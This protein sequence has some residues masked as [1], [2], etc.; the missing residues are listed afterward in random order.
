MIQTE[1]NAS[2]VRDIPQLDPSIPASFSTLCPG[3]YAPPTE[4]LSR[5][6]H[7]ITRSAQGHLAHLYHK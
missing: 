3:L 2:A 7:E 5:V 6:V 4:E 1:N